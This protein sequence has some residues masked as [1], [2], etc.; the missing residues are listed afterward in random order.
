MLFQAPSPTQ[1]EIEVIEQWDDIRRRLQFTL[2]KPHRWLGSLRKLI[3]ARNI[4]G[5]ISIEGH[6]VSLEDAVSAVGEGTP[7]AATG[8][9]LRALRGYRNALDYV[10]RLA[11]D[12]HF[13][14]DGSLLRTLHYLM[15]KDIRPAAPGRYRTGPIYVRDTASGEDRYEGAPA[16]EA[17]GLVEEL[18]E[19]LNREEGSEL[20]RGAMA[21]L[22]LI[23]I[24]PFTDGNGRMSRVL[25]TLVLARRQILHPVFSSIEEYLGRETPAYY[26]VL[27]EVGGPVWDPARD[28]R[29]WIRFVLTAHLRQAVIM[30]RRTREAEELW[31]ALDEYRRTTGLDE[32]TMDI[33]YDAA[34]DITIRRADYVSFSGVSERV[35][36]NDLR[37]LTE[38]GALTAQGEKR[39][40][41]YVAGPRLREL[42]SQTR[43]PRPPLPTPFP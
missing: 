20:V 37:R 15:M 21:H 13:R 23:M 26:G 31:E 28:A 42:R 12:P 7:R 1:T 16:E 34:Q 32:R 6:I 36:T 3:A 5:S 40:R 17:P 27:Q 2:G 25:Q 41:S 14:Y 30:E 18:A 43:K 11:D 4:R 38:A 10:I 39:G 8:E 22:N 19:E 33:L 9:D 29:P 24:H 35:A